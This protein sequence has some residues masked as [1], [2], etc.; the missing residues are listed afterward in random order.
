MFEKGYFWEYY[1]D[2][3]R[4]FANFLNYVPYLDGNE[5]VYSFRLANL[6]LSIGAHID[7]AFKEIYR[8]PEFSRRYPQILKKIETNKATIK[9]YLPISKEYC[10]FERQVRF[11]PLPKPAVILPFQ[12]YKK[13]GKVL[14]TPSWWTVYNN[15]KHEF[16][17]NFK[18]ANLKNVRNALAGAFLI[19]IVH[20]P[21]I[22]RLFSLGIAKLKHR[23]FPVRYG[24]AHEEKLSREVMEN[25]LKD[26]IYPPLF[27]ETELFFFDYEKPKEEEKTQ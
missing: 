24:S 25:I 11:N 8:Y 5:D 27:V 23:N 17:L 22:N 16:S 26:T 19:N 7:S 14:T 13:S 18:Q 10:L 4:Q 20:K 1:L 3:E 2:L 6:I 9:D 12:D 21:T 15:V